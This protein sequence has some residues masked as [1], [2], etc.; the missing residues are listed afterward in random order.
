MTDT[1]RLSGPVEVKADAHERVAF[2]LLTLIDRHEQDD[3]HEKTREYFLK[4]YEQCY[5]VTIGRTA[6]RALA[7]E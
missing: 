1:M 6:K 5:S 7:G 4:L 3:K 2:D